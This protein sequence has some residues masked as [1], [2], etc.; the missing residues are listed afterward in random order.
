MFEPKSSRGE[1]SRVQ[2][3]PAQ[4]SIVS[5]DMRRTIRQSKPNDTRAIRKTYAYTM[6]DCGKLIV[7]VIVIVIV[8]IDPVIPST[9][10]HECPVG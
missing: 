7:I 8:I 1:S 9:S 4:S 5:Q 2:S 6:F 10:S 3:S